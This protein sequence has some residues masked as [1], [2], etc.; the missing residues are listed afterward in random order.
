[1]NW[2]KTWVLILAAAL[3]LLSA[4]GRT[5]TPARLDAAAQENG[6]FLQE[7]TRYRALLIGQTYQ[8]SAAFPTLYGTVNDVRNMAL[9]LSRM[10][11]TPYETAAET[12]LTADGILSAIERHFA[13]AEERDVSLFYFSGHGWRSSDAELCGALVGTDGLDYVTAAQLRAALD[14]VPGRKIVI[15]DACYSGGFIAGGEFGPAPQEAEEA[16]ENG[17]REYSRYFLLTGAAENEE[18]FEYSLDDGNMGLFTASLTAAMGWDSRGGASCALLAD[19]DQN[20]AVTLQ[21][22]YAYTW[23]EMAAKGQH[24]QVYPSLCDWLVLARRAR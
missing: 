13:G 19:A 23:E 14:A 16:P 5:E 2:T 22:A 21:E 8:T 20:G 12:D 11:G 24:V 4:G 18:T 15:I 9:C 6:V 10:E 1:M 3:L 17:D 7:G